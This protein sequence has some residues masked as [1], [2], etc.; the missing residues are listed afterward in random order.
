L[1]KL[2]KIL[3]RSKYAPSSGKSIRVM[4]IDPVG[5]HGGMDF[6]NHQLC[7][8]LV[9]KGC[10][11]TLVTS[12]GFCSSDSD[13]TILELFKGVFGNDSKWI[14]AIKFAIAAIKSVFI[15]KTKGFNIVHF[16]IFHVGL[17]Q[18]LYILLARLSGIKIVI[19]A[20]DVGSF[21][22]GESSLLL[23]SIYRHC[24]EVIAHSQIGLKSLIQLDVCSSRISNIPLGNYTGLLPSLPK[25]EIAKEKFGFGKDDLVLLFFGQ[26]KKVK[27]LDLL[28][29]AVALARDMGAK[30]LRL[31]V[32]GPVTDADGPA[33]K[34][35]MADRLGD[36]VV[37]HSHFITN[38]DLPLY[39]AAADLAVLPYDRI[40]QSGVVLL[41]MS[42]GL[43]VLTSDIEG[44]LEVV[45]HGYSGLTFSRGD[46]A[47]L[48]NRLIE[49]DKDEWPLSDFTQSAHHLVAT[50][51]SWSECARLTVEVYRRVVY[52]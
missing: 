43:P 8:A 27:R 1:R 9:K 34:K 17:L 11:V 3:S 23:R 36:A 26:C 16:Q 52:D 29:E 28:I 15:A 40:L 35:Q 42:H 20:H 22:S 14:R 41:A 30:R 18:Y 46:L 51:Y 10:D 19:T 6:L 2:S 49:V 21:R 45:E 47:S 31:L 50:N 32:A 12:A 37:H 48:T 7:K 33:I 5:S 38:E 4:V 39:F 24:S 13:H 44:M 25:S